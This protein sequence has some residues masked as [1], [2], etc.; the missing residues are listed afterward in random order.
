MSGNDLEIRGSS[1]S[2]EFYNG[3]ADGD[4]SAE[5]MRIDSS[6]NVLVGTT[7]SSSSTAGI[8]LYPAGTA[9]FVRSGTHPLYVNRVTDDGNLVVFA[10]D[11]TTIG[12]IQSR[13]VVSTIILDPR[14]N[15]IGLTGTATAVIPT[16]NTGVLSN[17]AM[18]IGQSGIAFKDL[19]LSGGAYIGGTGAANKLDDYEEGT[20]T[21]GISGASMSGANSVA[22]YT[23]I[24]RQVFFQ[25]YSSAITISSASGTAYITGLPF[26]T[27]NATEAYGVFN[28]QH[29]NALDGGTTGGYV[30][31]ND[32]RMT[33]VDTAAT[34]AAT[35]IDGADKYIMVAGSY[36]AA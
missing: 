33:F 36:F 14:T 16:N 13:G 17:A 29:G 22:Y 6:G 5:R 10:R 31:I 20:W 8:K 7:S 11:G 4:S 18:D 12:S 35:F 15:G 28:Y 3:S 34:N 25:W 24:G 26:A 30:N 2:L 23:K 19:Y 9:A 21:A 27:S 32:S 1:G